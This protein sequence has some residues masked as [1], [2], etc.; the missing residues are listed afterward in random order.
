MPVYADRVK[1]TTAVVGT[2]DA[3]L[4]GAAS[5]FRSFATAFSGASP[6]VV[7]YAIV[8]GAE[9]EVGKGVFNGTDTI[10]RD[11]VR[12]SSNSNSLVPFSAGTK[13]IFVT[14][15]SE[16]IDNCNVGLQLAQSNGWALP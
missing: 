15:S 9:W 2:G 7:G 11:V 10:T 12:S 16:S 6:L 1:E 4:L 13:D 14:P 5:G 8:G 3:T